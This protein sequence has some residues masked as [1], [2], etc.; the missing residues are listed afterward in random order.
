MS[1]RR[2]AASTPEDSDNVEQLREEVRSLREALRDLA[3]TTKS[4][5]D[6][7]VNDP[8]EF[9]GKTPSLLPTF[10]FQV[11]LVFKAKPSTYPTEESKVTYAMTFLRGPV[12]AFVQQ[13]LEKEESPPWLTDF[14]SFADLLKSAFGNPDIIGDI[15]RKIRRLKQTDRVATYATDFRLLAGQLNWNNDA[16]VSQFFDGLSDQ[17][18]DELAKTVY[19]K[20]LG[21]LIDHAVRV[22]NLLQSRKTNLAH[23]RPTST[24]PTA[25]PGQRL[26]EPQKE[27]RR[28]NNLCMYCGGA[29][30]LVRSCPVRPSR[31]NG[32]P[33]PVHASEA[34]PPGKAPTQ[35][36]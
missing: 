9:D 24:V 10:L 3:A 33:L 35:L 2:L 23:L 25:R 7:K 36:L 29:D 34:K 20:D 14:S 26:T 19:P 13:C 5:K 6:P 16:L 1:N 12:E 15:S 27:Y 8:K 18:Q 11:G 30:H 22:D 21:E 31:P 4:A 28:K 17:I 32:P